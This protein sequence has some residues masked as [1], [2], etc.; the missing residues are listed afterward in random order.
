[1]R[2]D[3][4]RRRD[5]PGPADHGDFDASPIPRIK[6]HRRTRACGGREQQVAEIPGEHLHCGI[7]RSLP[8][9]KA[10]VAFDANQDPCPPGQANCVDQPAVAGPT[11]IG[12]LEPGR[13]LPLEG[14]RLASIQRGRVGYQLQAAGERQRLSSATGLGLHRRFGSSRLGPGSNHASR[15]LRAPSGA[16][17]DRRGDRSPTARGTCC[18][19]WPTGHWSATRCFPLKAT[20]FGQPST[21]NVRPIYRDGSGNAADRPKSLHIALHG[22]GTRRPF[23]EMP[24]MRP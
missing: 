6:P 11:T 16:Y 3:C 18:Q 17:S 2:V 5:L 15:P 9:P 13:D 10:Q 24:P 20:L 1:M 23:G 22:A 7:F 4:C 12:D 8:E 21:D 19:D 14:A